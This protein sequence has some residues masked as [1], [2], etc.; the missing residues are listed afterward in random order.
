M[1]LSFKQEVKKSSL[2]RVL[3]DYDYTHKVGF[4]LFMYYDAD[5]NIYM[6]SEVE[7]MQ[8]NKSEFNK[9]ILSTLKETNFETFY[10]SILDKNYISFYLCPDDGVFYLHNRIETNLQNL[11]YY[12]DEVESFN[13][14]LNKWTTKKPIKSKERVFYELGEYPFWSCFFDT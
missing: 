14:P 13:N 4:Y 5:N 11:E 7:Y 1:K 6:K 3:K 12:N 8:K 10:K 2:Y 9:H